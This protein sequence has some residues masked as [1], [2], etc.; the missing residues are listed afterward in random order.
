[1]DSDPEPDTF[2]RITYRYTLKR[3]INYEHESGTLL[4][5][6]PGSWFSV[7]SGCQKIEVDELQ[8]AI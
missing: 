8:R 3:P 6:G 2:L 4:N 1:M 7:K 5:A